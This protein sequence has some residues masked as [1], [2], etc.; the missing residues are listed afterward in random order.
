MRPNSSAVVGETPWSP[1]GF[2]KVPLD[3]TPRL[4]ELLRRAHACT[5]G[6]GLTVGRTGVE[7]SA[8]GSH[9]SSLDSQ[10]SGLT[11]GYWR[12]G[13]SRQFLEQNSTRCTRQRAIACAI[14]SRHAAR[15]GVEDGTSMVAPPLR[16]RVTMA[17]THMSEAKSFRPALLWVFRREFEAIT[18]EVD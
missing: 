13:R 11:R 18:C 16:L 1:A 7:F 17:T 12:D 2:F 10:R 8:G 5:R 4:R 3:Y 14:S 15:A 9:P 6:D